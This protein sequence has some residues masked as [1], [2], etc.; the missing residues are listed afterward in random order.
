MTG[1]EIPLSTYWDNKRIEWAKE[2]G[3][4]FKTRSSAR[5]VI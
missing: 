2:N 4:W 3:H 5:K 1:K